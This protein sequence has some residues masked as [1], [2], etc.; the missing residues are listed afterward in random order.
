M[1]HSSVPKC[2]PATTLIK[3]LGGLTAVSKAAGVSV[4]TVQRWRFPI[5]NGGTG[6]F[7]PRKHHPRLMEVAQQ[8]GVDLSPAAFVDVA[9]I[10]TP[11]NDASSTEA[12]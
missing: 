12:A 4:V 11:A 9:F 6:G 7:I 10:P 8:R 5:E 3:A 2:E 1:T